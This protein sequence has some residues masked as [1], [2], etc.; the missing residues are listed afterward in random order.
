MLRLHNISPLRLLLVVISPLAVCGVA[1][2]ATG[3]RRIAMDDYLDRVQAA[4]IGKMA[5]VGLGIATEFHYSHRIVPDS[6]MPAWRPETVNEGYNQ[7]D[8]YLQLAAL[9]ALDQ[10][11]LDV[12]SRTAY[13]DRANYQFEYGG[14]NPLF[15]EEHI[16]PPDLGHPH[17]KHTTD[18]CGYTCGSDFA[19]II[20]PGLPAMPV[21]MAQTFGT[22]S[23]YGDG[24]EAAIFLGSMYCEAF[25]TKDM[26]QVIATALRSIPSNSLTSQAVRDVVAWHGANTDWRTTWKEVMDKY[27]WN[28]ENNWTDWPYG[29][30][31][32]G[33]NLDSKS[34]AAFTVMALLYGGGDFERTMLIA[35]QASED[36]DCDASIACGIL[37]ASTGMK[38][39]PEKFYS[40]LNRAL[41]F[42]YMPETFA[43]LMA[44][45]EAVARKTIATEGGR[46]EN[47]VIIVPVS[48]LDRR[49]EK[50]LSSKDPG[51]VAGAV[52]TKAEM[53][54]VNLIVD[55]GFENQSGVWSFFLDN[56]ANHILP[57][58]N[59]AG[60]ERVD[61]NLART[62]FDNACLAVKYQAQYRRADNDPIFTG[63]RQRVQVEPHRRYRLTMW[64]WTAG[65][66][67]LSQRLM[68]SV[69]ADGQDIAE[70][71]HGA[72]NEWTQVALEFES[73]EEKQ[74][75]VSAGYYPLSG[76]ADTVRYDDFSLLP[77][78]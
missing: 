33:I 7:D 5:G 54:K 16:A 25:F 8:L 51:P 46:I 45:T 19:G 12:D 59:Y 52:F 43:G 42:K 69:A 70:V 2:G 6:M 48:V 35:V 22:A 38:G 31:N 9:R 37:A 14:R 10:H 62:G 61:K 73:G 56:H 65:G 17:F 74:V 77:V 47:G 13:I 4:W 68:L 60:L 26:Q 34:M 41:R 66:G 39:I 71:K 23:G 29:G 15:L 63:L 58:E 30:G 55:P 50:F 3:E 72:M 57:L 28:K 18:G 64:V 76:V 27:W 44:L 36:A 24:L 49:N 11:G 1:M 32:R 53:D 21:R 78:E 67:D 40:G 75:E 20:A